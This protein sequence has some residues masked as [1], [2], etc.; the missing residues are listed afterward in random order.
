[1]LNRL[2]IKAQEIREVCVRSATNVGLKFLILWSRLVVILS[3]LIIFIRLS[4]LVVFNRKGLRHRTVLTWEWNQQPSRRISRLLVGM[5]ITILGSRSFSALSTSILGRTLN[6][7]S[8]AYVRHFADKKPK[9]KMVRPVKLT[10]E[11]RENKLQTLQNNG[12]TLHESRD[13]ICKTFKFK[14]FVEAFD[15]MKAVAGPAEEMDH[16]PEWFNVYNRVD[17]T[18]STHDCNGLSEN[19][20]KL[21]SV[22][23]SL[24]K[25]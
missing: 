22:I 11:D 10:G 18:L 12:W 23:D 2:N 1:M 3:L 15:F 6:P 8:S 24:N 16:H 17:I 20:V 4:V 25:K 19:D 14:N 9:R 5:S 21:A 7:F 13:A